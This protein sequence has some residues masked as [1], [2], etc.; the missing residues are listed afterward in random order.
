MKEKYILAPYLVDG[1]FDTVRVNDV[2]N[3]THLYYSFAVIRD[4]KVD[5]SHLK[6]IDKLELLKKINP[7]LKIL[8]SIGGWSAGGFSEA[9]FTQ[10]GRELFAETACEIVEKYNLDGLDIDWEYPSSDQAGIAAH[11][12]DKQNFTLMLKELRKYL[13]NITAKTSIKQLLTIAV[14]ASEDYI[15]GTDM[16]EAVKYLDYVNLMTYDMRGGFTDITGHHTNL[17]YQKGIDEGPSAVRTVRI[18]NQA[19]VPVEK[20]I[21]GSAFYGRC[22]KN[23]DS[24]TDGI[25]SKAES[26]GRFT[27]DYPVLAADFINKNG[28]TKYW[29]DIAKAPYLFNGK[30]FI[31][32]D[33][34]KSLEYKCDYVKQNKLAG[35]MFWEY[36]IDTKYS[37]FE[38]ICKA[39]NN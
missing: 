5:S 36:S 21:L 32:Y 13:D 16:K 28:Y 35:I 11:P 38:A 30:D 26:V 33:D 20:M 12:D 27:Y 2:I 37:L 8:L 4:G 23:V 19:G 17:Y 14:G 9:A 25:A 15:T 7:K 31:S 1:G 22:W 18:F 10:Q 3:M 24:Q 6:N 29:D 34:E 39:I